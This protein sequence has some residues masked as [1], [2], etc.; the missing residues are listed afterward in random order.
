M[1]PENY[2]AEF[3]ITCCPEIPPLVTCRSATIPQKTKAPFAKDTVG[4]LLLLQIFS[5]QATSG[6]AIAQRQRF[7]IDN[8]ALRV[9]KDFREFS[10]RHQ[11]Q[12]K[13]MNPKKIHPFKAEHVFAAAFLRSKA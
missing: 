3:R 13:G 9:Y 4:W 1:N 5:S 12:R 7:T 8:F 2:S 10:A 6:Y 11:A